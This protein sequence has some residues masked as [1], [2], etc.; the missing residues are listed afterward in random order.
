VDVGSVADI[1]S[2]CCLNLQ[3]RNAEVGCFHVHIVFLFNGTGGRV[4]TDAPSGPIGTVDGESCT[5]ALVTTTE[6]IKEPSASGV[7]T[8][9]L[10]QVLT[11]HDV[12]SKESQ[13]Y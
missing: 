9:S 1:V 4:G 10:I 11:T 2:S 6:S 7:P 8:G 13:D 3:G 5:M 12:L